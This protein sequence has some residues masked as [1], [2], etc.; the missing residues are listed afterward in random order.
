MGE[1][2]V[3]VDLGGTK[4]AA[5]VFNTETQTLSGE[6]TVPTRAHEGPDG[7]L[8]QIAGLVQ[9]V[10]KRA[11]VPLSDVAGVGVGMPATFD[12][13]AGQTLV[14]PNIPGDWWRKPVADVLQSQLDKPITLVNDARSF[15]LAE[16]NLG[17]GRGYDSVVGITLGTG[18]GGGIAINGKLYLGLA[19]AAGEVGHHSID[20]NGVPDGTGNPGGW[21]AYGS[22]PAIAAMG[23]K[24][25]MQGINTRIGKLVD[26]DLNK[27][28]PGVILEA[29][30]AGDNVAQDILQRAG[31]Y[32]GAGLSNVLIIVAPHCVVIG[33]GVAELG[34]WILAPMRAGI[35]RR[36]RTVPIEKLA[37]KR[38][39]LG[40]RAG[41]YG[42][43]LHAY[44]GEH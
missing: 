5:G 22:G 21:E 9:D 44:R 39:E 40:G 20:F 7:V 8:D 32:L 1:N 27:I 41:V 31:D 4:I 28:T 25:V 43:A 36:C 38:A 13:D 6:H 29:A 24:A 30:K 10:C 15:T 23:V 17:A 37:I 14:L 34:E 11:N 26:Y 33:G 12:L 19:G 2:Y 3:G 35:E 16:A 18:I 42:S